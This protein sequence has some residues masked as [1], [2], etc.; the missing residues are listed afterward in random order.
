MRVDHQ[1]FA[2]SDIDPD[3]KTIT[4]KPGKLD[5]TLYRRKDRLI[6]QRNHVHSPVE[7]GFCSLCSRSTALIFEL[8]KIGTAVRLGKNIIGTKRR[9]M[10]SV[11]GR[12][13]GPA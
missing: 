2:T 6:S 3:P 1:K 10:R 7:P 4:G 9:A 12:G 11:A 13:R 5:R 8:W